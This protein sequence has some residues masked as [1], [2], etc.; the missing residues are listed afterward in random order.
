M[1]TEKMARRQRRERKR[2][3]LHRESEAILTGARAVGANRNLK[4]IHD[5]YTHIYPHIAQ[6]AAGAVGAVGAVAAQ[7]GGLKVG[8]EGLLG[9]LLKSLLNRAKCHRC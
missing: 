5:I 7:G 3:H 2:G 9:H 1:L 8:H 6:A 4:S